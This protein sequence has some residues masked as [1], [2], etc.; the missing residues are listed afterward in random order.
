VAAFLTPNTLAGVSYCVAGRR[1][2]RSSPQERSRCGDTAANLGP[3]GRTLE[4]GG[5]ILARSWRRSGA[6]PGAAVW[7]RL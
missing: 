2:R 5:D 1:S 3:A 7:I 6:M 4:L